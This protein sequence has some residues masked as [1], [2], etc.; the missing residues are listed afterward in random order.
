M[1]CY[2]HITHA[3]VY[4]I[5]YILKY[6]PLASYL[7]PIKIYLN[8]KPL[9]QYKPFL[10]SL[11]LALYLMYH[12]ILHACIIIFDNIAC[13]YMFLLPQ[14]LNNKKKHA[15]SSMHVLHIKYF[16]F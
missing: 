5:I 6:R 2:I 4:S 8:I 9:Y 15:I 3:H 14:I 12:V 11:L 10:I 16:I 13:Y 1:P 7:T